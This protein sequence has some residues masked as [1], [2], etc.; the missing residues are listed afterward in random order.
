MGRIVG[1]T[2]AG[3]EKPAGENEP[4]KG[5]AGDSKPARGKKGADKKPA[6][7]KSPENGGEKDA[8]QAETP[9]KPGGD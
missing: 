1:L 9:P 8:G 7:D 3:D 4:N 6:G 5:S 2:F